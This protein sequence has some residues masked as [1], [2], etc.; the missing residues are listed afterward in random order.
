MGK[1]ISHSETKITKSSHW[2]AVRIELQ[3]HPP[4]LP[5]GE[6]SH[7]THEEVHHDTTHISEL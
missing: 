5:T 1:E 7:D 4:D 2:V 3:K 6:E